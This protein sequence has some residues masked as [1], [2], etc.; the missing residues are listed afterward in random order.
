MDQFVVS[1]RKYRPDTFS[2]VIG[3]A[4]ITDTLK[5]AILSNQLAQA[6]LF[7]GPRGVGK[8]TCA[9]I[10][11]K[12]VNCTQLTPE[13][14]PCNTCDSC[15]AFNTGRSISI[16]ELDAA[17]N[18][19]VDDIRNLI[20]QVRF[21]PAGGAKAVY[22]VDEVHML[23]ASA[24][25][26]F[27][28]TLE[29]PPRHAIFILATTEKNKILPTILSRCQ[30]FDF[31]RIKIQD[32]ANHLADIAKKEDITFEMPALQMIA[33]KADGALRDALSYFDQ[34][35]AFSN[36]KITFQ[37]ALENLN[38][39]DYD[40]YFKIQE[41]IN[42]R[43]HSDAL[44]IFQEILNKGFDA[45]NFISGLLQH[46]RNLLMASEPKTMELLQTSDNVKNK[47]LKAAASLNESFLLNAFQ[48]C[49]DSE[50][51]YRDTAN[52]NL[53]IELLLIKLVYLEDAILLAGSMNNDPHGGADEKKK[54]EARSELNTSVSSE[55][56]NPNKGFDLN[57]SSDTDG[58]D[59][60][61]THQAIQETPPIAKA[62]AAQ[63][64]AMGNARAV[65]MPAS[66]SRNSIIP[67]DLNDLDAHLQLPKAN[68]HELEGNTPY[69]D[70]PID[71]N[72]F[73]IAYNK[74]IDTLEAEHKMALASELKR[75]QWELQVNKWIQKINNPASKIIFE[76]HRSFL[77]EFL[78]LELEHPGVRLELQM[79]ESA[80]DDD[81]TSVPANS[82]GRLRRME[83]LYPWLSEFIR[84]HNANIAYN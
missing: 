40:Y 10:L 8:T 38:I 67:K 79:Q 82:E 15:S 53:L 54:S 23:S 9:R 76:E 12:A 78:R 74:L 64:T 50:I 60:Q 2:S 45:Y 59:A 77:L 3:Q 51:K 68:Q 63:P 13:G 37:D 66:F 47:Y 80:A 56:A 19:S 36:R 32:M 4:H 46:Y 75:N 57:E 16:H 28:K 35:S 42:R 22:I 65:E 83:T 69:D 81:K 71:A 55:N 41:A 48:L 14:D 70:I 7:C 17:S 31:R 21:V 26:A 29:E 84:K 25:N 49:S 27:L 72:A 61:V 18:N 43:S 11:A 52:P 73:Q 39:L 6:F 5:N 24:F 34:V 58:F 33:L 62:S 20:E 44:L 30:K 1:F